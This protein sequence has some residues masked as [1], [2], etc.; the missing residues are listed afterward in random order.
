MKTPSPVPIPRKKSVSPIETDSLKSRRITSDDIISEIRDDALS[1]RSSATASPRSK[2]IKSI[3]SSRVSKLTDSSSSSSDS[4]STET[5]S[6]D[7]SEVSSSENIQKVK[8]KKFNRSVTSSSRHSR[9]VSKNGSAVQSRQ[10]IH[11][12]KK[13]SIASA[14]IIL[15]IFFLKPIQNLI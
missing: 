2:S 11:S 8:V 9:H 14:G 7:D 12:S 1:A 3:H 5:E 4:E 6:S 10:S 15:N 13:D